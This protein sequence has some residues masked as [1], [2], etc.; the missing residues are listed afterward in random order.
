M[1]QRL[2][3]KDRAQGILNASNKNQWSSLC[4]LEKRPFW[5]EILMNRVELDWTASANFWERSAD[6]AMPESEDMVRVV[7]RGCEEASRTL[8]SV[9]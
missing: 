2:A 4:T 1:L 9:L 3:E 6:T 7:I 5:M 8:F